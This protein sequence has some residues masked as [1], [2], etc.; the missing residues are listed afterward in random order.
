[1]TAEPGPPHSHW[2][3]MWHPLRGK[4]P[5]SALCFGLLHRVWEKA[6]EH[7]LSPLPHPRGMEVWRVDTREENGKS[8]L[9]LPLGWWWSGLT[10]PVPLSVQLEEEDPRLDFHFCFFFRGCQCYGLRPRQTICSARE[11]GK[12]LALILTE[13][14]VLEFEKVIGSSLLFSK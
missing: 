10:D 9:K 7:L 13:S 4:S 11:N 3:S 5:V 1:M 2:R 8:G 6:G 14:L 12:S